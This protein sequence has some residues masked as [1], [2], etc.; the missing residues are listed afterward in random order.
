VRFAW[1][2]IQSALMSGNDSRH[3]IR[4]AV[5]DRESHR[6]APVSDLKL[7]CRVM[8]T[9]WSQHVINLSRAPVRGLGRPPPG[10]EFERSEARRKCLPHWIDRKPVYAMAS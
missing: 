8:V 2:Q 10:S 3:R 4:F 7:D 5:S 1:T 6:A 9:S